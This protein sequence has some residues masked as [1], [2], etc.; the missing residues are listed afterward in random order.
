MW[1]FPNSHITISNYHVTR[2]RTNGYGGVAIVTHQSINSSH[3]VFSK[4]IRHML[5]Y[6]SIN[7]VD[8]KTTINDRKFDLWSIYI[9]PSFNPSETF[10]NILSLMNRS[11]LIGG[12]FNGHHPVWGSSNTDFR[13]NL[14]YSTLSDFG[15]CI[16]NK[17]NATRINRRPYLDTMF[18]SFV[19]S[20]NI[21]YHCL[22]L[23]P[24]CRSRLAV[25][26]SL[27]L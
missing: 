25:I 1:L 15:L 20:P 5:E 10:N 13:G 9:P 23:G 19:S 8:I 6:H 18:D 27:F 22:V 21:L 24:C 17:G 11:S 12:D 3:I 14:I 4:N 2:N 26:I 7:L 16:L